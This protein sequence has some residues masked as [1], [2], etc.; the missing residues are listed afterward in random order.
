MGAAFVNYIMH[1][2][3]AL[4]LGV[5]VWVTFDPPFSPRQLMPETGLRCTRR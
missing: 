5:L 2:V 3:N 4:I 1:V